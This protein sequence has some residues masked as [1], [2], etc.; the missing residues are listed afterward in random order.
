MNPDIFIISGMLSREEC[1]SL[2]DA[3]ADGQLTPI[4]Y[5]NAVLLNYD[6]LKPLALVILAGKLVKGTQTMHREL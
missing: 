1:Q 5:Q 2:I 4:S 3:A 6:R